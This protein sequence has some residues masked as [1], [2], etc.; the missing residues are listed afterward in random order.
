MS[1]LPG[2]MVSGSGEICLD[3]TCEI[4]GGVIFCAGKNTKN[5]VILQM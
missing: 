2:P 5:V 4:P 3:L 1:W